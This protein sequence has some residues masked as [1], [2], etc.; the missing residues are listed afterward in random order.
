M[1]EVRERWARKAWTRKD[2]C[3]VFGELWCD[4]VRDVG[5]KEGGRV[6]WVILQRPWSVLLRNLDFIASKGYPTKGF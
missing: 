3:N 5:G 1:S 4:R 6:V 2:A